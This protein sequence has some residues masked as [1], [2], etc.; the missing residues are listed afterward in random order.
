MKK[1]KCPISHITEEY[2]LLGWFSPSFLLPSKLIISHLSCNSLSSQPSASL[3]LL[4][5]DCVG[6]CVRICCC[7]LSKVHLS[8]NGLP[9]L[10]V[11]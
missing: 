2:Q 5:I 8:G 11:Q 9:T 3:P 7:E 4:Q 10:A 1:K 6:V